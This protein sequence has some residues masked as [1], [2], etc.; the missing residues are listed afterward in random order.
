[1]FLTNAYFQGIIY[2]PNLQ[3]D[4][5]AQVGMGQAVVAV[6]ENSLDYYI[7]LYE[8]EFLVRLLGVRLYNAFVDG[9]AGDDNGKWGKLKE[10]IFDTSGTFPVSP[11]ANY[12]YYWL[13]RNGITTTTMKGEVTPQQDYARDASPADKL[14]RAWNGMLPMIACIR[15]FIIDNLEDYGHWLDDD[16]CWCVFEPINVLGL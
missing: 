7:Q 6:A 8:R 4:R 10:K 12:V 11:A 1:M 5:P 9:L 13:V 2:L 14:V 15:A 16:E 3:I